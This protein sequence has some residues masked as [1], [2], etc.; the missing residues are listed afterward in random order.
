[1]VWSVHKEYFEKEID[2]DKMSDKIICHIYV[3]YIY[4]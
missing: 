3:Q 1:M 2:H 4:T